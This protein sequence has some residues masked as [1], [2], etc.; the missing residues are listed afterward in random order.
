M[1]YGMWEYAVCAAIISTIFHIAW[2]N[3]YASASFSAMTCS[4]ANLA[5][6]A[7]LANWQVNWGWFLPMLIGGIVFAFPVCAAAGVPWL[8]L[9]RARSKKKQNKTFNPLLNR[10]AQQ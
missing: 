3:L 10:P 2:S 7:W 6:E 8:L 4:I 1:W 9:R 5:Y